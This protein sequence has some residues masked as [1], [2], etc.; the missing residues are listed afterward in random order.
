M[1]KLDLLRK[2]IRE[3]VKAVFQEELAGILK[4][5]IMVNKGTT[6]VESIQPRKPQVPSTLNNAQPRV[7]A[8][9]LGVGN[10]LSSLLAETAKSMTDNDLESLGG[11]SGVDR[12]VPI[13]ESVNGMFAAARPSS[14]M[15][16]IEIN[17]VP[18]F[19]G[20]MAKMKA[21]GEI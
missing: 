8:P 5:A 15:D 17:A 6:I 9:N 16:A 2:I 19:T 3:E 12:D 1:A 10:P 7:V 14:N 13:V 11:V 21:N 18:D 20:L 4:E